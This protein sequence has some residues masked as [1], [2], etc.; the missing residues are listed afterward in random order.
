[1]LDHS[2]R[3]SDTL[4]SG[5]VYKEWVVSETKKALLLSI[6]GLKYLTWVPKSLINWE[7]RID[8]D[9]KKFR[10]MD[11]PDMMDFKLFKKAHGRP[12]SEISAADLSLLLVPEGRIPFDKSKIAK[13]KIDYSNQY[14]TE[15]HRPPKID[16]VRRDADDSLKR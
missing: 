1:M 11:L 6:P 5:V 8:R 15:Y 2:N 14:H 13:N 3:S 4:W 12:Y 7:T 10:F 9:G 16:P